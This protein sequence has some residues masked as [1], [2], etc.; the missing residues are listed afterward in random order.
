[1]INSGEKSRKLHAQKRIDAH[2]AFSLDDEDAE[3]RFPEAAS[4]LTPE[5]SYNRR[6]AWMLLNQ[7]LERLTAEYSRA[8]KSRQFEALKPF[9]TAESSNGPYTRVAA[10]LRMTPGAVAVAVH[11]AR[12]RFRQLVRSEV[13]RTVSTA[14]ELEDELR[15]LFA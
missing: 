13:A 5:K 3:G 2:V 7:A 15:S 4:D 14:A 1:M 12:H 8:G 9:L 10:E 11:R 6:W